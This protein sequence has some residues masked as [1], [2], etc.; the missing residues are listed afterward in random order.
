MSRKFETAAIRAGY[1]V[2]PTSRSLAV[3]VY[4]TT[5][6]QF[7][8]AEQAAKLFGLQE[9]GNI[10]TRLTNSTQ[11][12]LE[13][14]ITELEGGAASLAFASG[15]AA[16]FATV[17]NILSQGENIVASSKLY[18]GTYTM[19]N[20]IL[21]QFGITTTFVD[22]NDPSS[23]EK[24]IDK[25]TRL[26][27]TETIGNPALDVAD[28]GAIA[29][30]AHK[31]GLPL[32]VDATFTTPYLFRA[33][34]AGADIVI[35]SLSKWINGH[36]TAIG[37]IVTDS[38]KFDW[39]NPKFK[40][41]NEPDGSY[42]GIRWAHDLGDLNP[43]AFTIRQRT[44]PLR[45]LGAAI[46]PDSAWYF[47]Q[48]LETLA[49][50]MDQHSK[51][52]L[53]V[54]KYLEKHPKVDWVRY[55]GL[56]SHP[57][58]DV[59]KKYLKKGFGGMVVFGLKGGKEAGAKFIDDLQVFSHVANVGD[60]KSLAIHPASTTHS[61]LTEE[62]QKSGGI[63]PELVRLSVGIENIDDIIADLEQAIG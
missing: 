33:I 36:G 46:S 43:V 1:T 45:N 48:G 37:G 2:E 10:Y 57:S 62:Q 3:P 20:N 35:H 6:Y 50:R 42:H 39:T 18:G 44:I 63:S 56:A 34:D 5:A 51:N 52:A 4:R 21:P 19:F 31:A 15:T 9:L 8:S 17:V 59:A 26:V 14:R 24:A 11:S 40:L 38:G 41:Y 27:Y 55:P 7:N 12:V 28:I 25:N 30:V 29:A 23:F 47:L 58:H 53:T 16:I 22:V 13:D 61:Q 54:A 49:L 32:A 60:A